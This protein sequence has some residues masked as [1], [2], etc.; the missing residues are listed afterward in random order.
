MQQ[1]G[2]RRSVSAIFGEIVFWLLIACGALAVGAGL[3]LGLGGRDVVGGI[4]SGYYVR[5][6]IQSGDEVTVAG[7]EGV[8]RD[9]GPVATVIETNKGGMKERRTVPN[10]LMLNEAVR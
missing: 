6:R 8:V 7:I 9:V 4:L 5:Q 10:T 3:A 2:N 1:V